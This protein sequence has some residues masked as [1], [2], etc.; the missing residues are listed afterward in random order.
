MT[1]YFLKDI[2]QHYN[3]RTVL[4]IS[5]LALTSGNIYTLTGPNGAGKTTLLNIL[6][7]LRPPSSGQ[8]EFNHLPVT[9]NAACLQ[10][11]R[12]SVVLVDQHPI[13]FSTTVYKNIEFGLKIRKIPHDKRKQIIQSSLDMVGMKKFTNADA[14]FLSG[15]ETRRVAIARAMACSPDVLIM[16]E[17]TADLDLEHQMT[18]ETIILDIHRQKNITIIFCTHNLAQGARLTSH[19]IHLFAGQIQDHNHE[20]IFKGEITKIRGRHYCRITEKVLIPTPATDKRETK[21]SIHPTA[22]RVADKKDAEPGLTILKGKVIGL[23]EDKERIRATIDVGV[24]IS[25][26][27]EAS[28]YDVRNIRINTMVDVEINPDGVTLF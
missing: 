22:I 8:M 9:F 6:S 23:S 12:K 10:K 15:G 17:P 25:L 27:M 2:R 4:N 26:L 24:L 13:L 18:I 1:L 21:I 11:L 5:E 19:H 20:N 7:F 16:D 3:H 14:R 28:E